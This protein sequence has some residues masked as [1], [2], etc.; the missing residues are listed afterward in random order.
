MTTEIFESGIIFLHI[1]LPKMSQKVSQICVGNYK[2]R[3][4]M[5]LSQIKLRKLS[6]ISIH[7][8]AQ[9]LE[10][11]LSQEKIPCTNHVAFSLFSTF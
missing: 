4:F 9:C 10:N 1:N 5:I 11:Q 2:G 7:N 8:S 6:I 3:Y